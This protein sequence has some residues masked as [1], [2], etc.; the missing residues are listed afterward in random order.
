MKKFLLFIMMLS[1]SIISFSQNVS[2]GLG[3]VGSIDSWK[4]TSP[5]PGNAYVIPNVFV[6]IWEPTPVSGANWISVSP[7]G[8][9]A[10]MTD[11]IYEKTLTPVPTSGIKELKCNFKVAADDVLKK[12][13][14]VNGSTII[15]IPFTISATPYKFTN[16]ITE[17]VKCPKAGEWKLRITIFCGDPKGSTGPTALL[18]SGSVDQTQGICCDCG[19]PNTNVNFSICSTLGG[20]TTATASALGA[21]TGLGNGWTLKQVTCPS[22]NPC[23]WLPGGIKWQTTGSTISI[24]STVLTPGCYVL[25]HYVNRCSKQWDPKQCL[26][27]RSICFTICDNGIT[28]AQD[29]NPKMAMKRM[30]TDGEKV[31]LDEV[32]KEA[33]V[34]GE[35]N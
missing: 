30:S 22:T 19:I 20:G 21:S 25:T 16:L 32:E 6:G 33:E 18:V 13:E 11:F 29:V 4:V 26:S 1:I 27:Y 9:G 12:I 2:T 3:A 31:E 10:G 15:N 24:P 28:T 7:S 35:K 34:I 5:T 17:V 8:T 23:K 14:L